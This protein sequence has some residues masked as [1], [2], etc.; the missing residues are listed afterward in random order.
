VFAP[1]F[2]D[3]KKIVPKTIVKIPAAESATGEG[4]SLELF[5][6]VRRERMRWAQMLKRV[7]EV[8]VT[9]CPKC[10][11]RLEQIAVIKDRVV[12]KALLESLSE[13]TVFKPLV[14]VPVRGPP[15]ADEYFQEFTED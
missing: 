5:V 11:G 6:K 10:N 1:N 8:D 12:I 2:K 13:V 14:V 3:R 9:I 4:L 7:F 15:V